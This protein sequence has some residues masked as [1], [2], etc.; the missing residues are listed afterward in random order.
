MYIELIDSNKISIGMNNYIQESI[1]IF[2]ED[3]STKVLSAE[4]KNIH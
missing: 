2:D 3:V 1:E 4:D